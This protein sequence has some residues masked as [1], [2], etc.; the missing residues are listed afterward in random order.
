MPPRLVG[1][2]R[3]HR[4]DAFP[5]KACHARASRRI[6]PLKQQSANFRRHLK[7]PLR[8][9]SIQFRESNFPSRTPFCFL[10]ILLF[11][12]A[13]FENIICQDSFKKRRWWKVPMHLDVMRHKP[14]RRVDHIPVRGGYV[15]FAIPP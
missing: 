5:S 13:D 2:D 10:S 14:R 12:P 11:F 9:L 3:V 1:N 4:T 7:A 6:A 15:N 8:P